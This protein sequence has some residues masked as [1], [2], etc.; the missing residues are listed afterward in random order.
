MTRKRLIL[1]VALCQSLPAIAEQAT[2]PPGNELLT[3]FA[4]DRDIRADLPAALRAPDLGALPS[5]LDNRL[6]ELFDRLANTD[7]ARASLPI[8]VKR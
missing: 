5:G 4:A 3:C 1:L 7:V 6:N 2:E 8:I